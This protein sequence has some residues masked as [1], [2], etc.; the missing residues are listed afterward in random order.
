MKNANEK[1]ITRTIKAATISLTVFDLE[2]S[3]LIHPSRTVDFS[4]TKM[5]KDER[6]TYARKAFETSTQ[7]I[8][9]VE[10]SGTIEKK[11]ACTIE[12]FL[13]VANVMTK[14]EEE[15]EKEGE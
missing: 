1:L 7:K 5:T 13:S 6:L 14:E 11:Y 3:G 15:E 4:V 9:D 2:T 8:V 10:I 12:Q